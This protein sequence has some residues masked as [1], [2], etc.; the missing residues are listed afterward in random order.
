MLAEHTK[1]PSAACAEVIKLQELIQQLGARKGEHSWVQ[2]TV[3]EVQCIYY[4]NIQHHQFACELELTRYFVQSTKKTLRHQIFQ[5]IQQWQLLLDPHLPS[6]QTQSWGLTWLIKR[7][8]ASHIHADGRMTLQ[9]A[10]ETFIGLHDN[11][12]SIG[13]SVLPT[14][15]AGHLLAFCF[16]NDDSD[17]RMKE[18]QLRVP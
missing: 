3:A 7:P 10:A 6:P 5:I 14:Q 9:D 13:I 12:G 15:Q 18:L 11:C 2:M 17:L 4:N 1:L 16:G 8:K